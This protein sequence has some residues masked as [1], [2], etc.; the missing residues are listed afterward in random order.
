MKRQPTEWDKIF[1]NHIS[2]KDLIPKIHKEI[3]QLKSKNPN[4]NLILKWVEE[5]N[6]HFSKEA[7]QMAKRYM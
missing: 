4:S 2:D 7:I 6:R 3:I 1:P 5:V